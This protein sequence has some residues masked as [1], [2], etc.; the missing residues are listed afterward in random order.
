MALA[1]YFN[2]YNYDRPHQSLSYKTPADIYQPLVMNRLTDTNKEKV[3]KRNS[4]STIPN[5]LS[6]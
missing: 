6:I 3:T 2:F 4:T 1:E 5:E